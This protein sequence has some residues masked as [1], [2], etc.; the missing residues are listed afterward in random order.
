MVITNE[1]KLVK[2]VK[3]LVFE[4]ILGFMR[5]GAVGVVIN[6]IQKLSAGEYLI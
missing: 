1:E 5:M 4:I 3:N 2:R 6:V